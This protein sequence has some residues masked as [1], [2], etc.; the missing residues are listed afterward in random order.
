MSEKRNVRR[1][2]RRTIVVAI[3]ALLV[4]GIALASHQFAD[5]PN[6]NNYHNDIDALA[7]AGVTTGCGDGSTYCPG[8]FVTRE[9]M[10]AFMNRLGALGA[11]K[12]PVVNA[13]KLDGLD[14]TD[15]VQHGT[16]HFNCLGRDMWPVRNTDGNLVW[17]T[18]D[19]DFARSANG[20]EFACSVH[21]PDGA[22]VSAFSVGVSVP[23]AEWGSVQ[24]VLYR[25]R[26]LTVGAFAS[27][28]SV[29][30]PSGTPGDVVLQ[31]TTVEN[32]VIDNDVYGYE[33]VCTIIALNPSAALLRG[34]SV[35]Y[36]TG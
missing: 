3:C 35:E 20:A 17:G 5:V 22:L 36:T 25:A 28:A 1:V 18:G 30:S 33:A 29:A 7:D 24:C 12:T 23:L 21:L 6:T 4:P 13:T 9:Q 32:A 27:M 19:G 31:D 10:A 26:V 16:D 15:F 2:G 8:A 14:S 11:G 34:I